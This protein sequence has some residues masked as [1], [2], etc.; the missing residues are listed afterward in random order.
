MTEPADTP[1][2]YDPATLRFYAD[3]AASYAARDKGGP[4]RWLD[5]FLD[6]LPAG[7]RILELGCGGG[8]D[9]MHMLARGFDVVPT[10]GSP[11]MAAEAEARL[12]RPVR[13]LRFDQLADRDAYD[14]VWANASLL[15]VP[16]EA[17]AGV[18]ASVFRAL[19][20]GGQHFA[21]YK[22]GDRGKRDNY[23]RYYNYPDKPALLDA[24][25]QAGPWESLAT[26]AYVGSELGGG[27]IPWLAVTAR[28]PAG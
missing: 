18:L 9:S 16:G 4:S 26:K 25:A 21:S 27:Q 28:R 10:D 17:L 7:A 15:H 23:G 19:R 8:R 11:E 20:P 14:A 5:E 2:A 3:N 24:Y 6:G 12:G 13:T 22:A 1:L